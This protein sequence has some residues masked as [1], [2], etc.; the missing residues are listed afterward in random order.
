MVQA[1]IHNTSC[2]FLFCF[3]VCFL[4]FSQLSKAHQDTGVVITFF[5]GF[6]TVQFLI[7]S[8]SMRKQRGRSESI[9]H[10]QVSTCVCVGRQSWGGVNL[11]PRLSCVGGEKRAWY[12]LFA[13]AQFSQDSGNLEAT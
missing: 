4:F 7:C 10:I 8:T 9:H 11:V 3:F 2:L 13:H 6:L 12:T 5:P 1:Q